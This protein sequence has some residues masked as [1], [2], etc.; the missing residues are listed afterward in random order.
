MN[1]TVD[2]D[3]L[4]AG[5]E[6]DLLVLEKVMGYELVR[7]VRHRGQVF[8]ASWYQGVNFYDLHMPTPFSTDMTAA[9]QVVEK[10]KV[11]PAK[12]A[13]GRCHY[14]KLVANWSDTEDS[15]VYAYFDW[16]G[17]GDGNPLYKAHAHN[18]AEAICKAALKA[19]R[20]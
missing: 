7:V 1:E 4:E 11:T 10:M 15:G 9:W 20:G 12:H 13:E 3:T 16:Q 5:P 19:V 17:T 8:G 18:P 6:L 14:L 2:I